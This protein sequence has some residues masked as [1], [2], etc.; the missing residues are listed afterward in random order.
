MLARRLRSVG[1]VG[2]GVGLALMALLAACADDGPSGAEDAGVDA[3]YIDAGGR[4]PDSAVTP[5]DS[6]DGTPDTGPAD[7][8]VKDTGPKDTGPPPDTTPPGS[9]TNLAATADTHASVTLTWTAPADE[10]DAGTVASYEVRYATT[11]ITN[12]TDFGAATSVTGPTPLAAGSAQTLT[13]TGLLPSTEYHFALRAKDAANNSG[14]LSNDA[15][16]TTKPRAKLLVTEIAPLNTATEGGDFVELVATTAGSTADLEVRHSSTGA[17]ALLYKLGALDVNVGDWLVVHA[18]GAP[19]PAGFAQEDTTKDKTS[20]TDPAASVD[21]YDVYSTVDNLL[22]TNSTIFVLDGTAYQDAV[23]YSSRATDATTASM[24]AYSDAFLAGQWTF[25]AAPV[26]G[27]NDCPTELEAV[28][29]SGSTSPPCG[30]WPGFL[31]AGSSIQRN[32]VVDTNTRADFFVAAQTRG[33]ANAPFCAPEGAALALTEVNPNPDLLELTV[34]TGGSL[35]GF[36][37]RRDPKTGDNG[38]LLATLTPICAAAGDVVVLHLGATAGTPS[39]TTAKDEQPLA[40][41][42]TFYD[43]AWDVAS[44]SGSSALPLATSLVVAVRNPSGAYVEAAPFSNMTT[45]PADGGAYQLSL[46]FIQGLGLWLPAD[47]GG[48]SPCTTTTTPTARDIAASWN[49]VGAL[50]TDASCKRS[51]STSAKQAS[52]WSVGTSS[53]GQ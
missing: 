28:N 41:H 12:A 22:S 49:G 8:G 1:S 5:S 38:T 7:T 34:T 23:P 29:A 27:T 24:T 10:A 9:V 4:S 46:T 25:S 45:T 32:G 19:G 15:T 18:V 30:G 43:T 14:A 11:P 39:E 16:A 53:F 17:S 51:S 40:T 2:F 26:D 36:T 20:S 37:V 3:P 48:V 6:G 13:V 47:C 44:T 50:A 21:A 33:A 35:R 31:A 42:P 52:S